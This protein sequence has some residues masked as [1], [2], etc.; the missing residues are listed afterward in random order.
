MRKRLAVLFATVMLSDRSLEWLRDLNGL[1]PGPENAKADDVAYILG[2]MANTTPAWTERYSAIVRRYEPLVQLPIPPE[3]SEQ[4][5]RLASDLG[6][7]TST[8]ATS[9]LWALHGKPVTHPQVVEIEFPSVA[10]SRAEWIRGSLYLQMVRLH[11]D[12]AAWTEFRI[13]GVEPRM[14]DITGVEGVR[15]D[16]RAS[17]VNVRV[18]LVT[19][20]LEFTPGSY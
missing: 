18:P 2:L 3:P 11:E 8:P 20:W 15:I 4:A 19:G 17:G 14:W 1:M 16:V 13:I 6:L 10:L 9:D 12:A 7:D 5:Q